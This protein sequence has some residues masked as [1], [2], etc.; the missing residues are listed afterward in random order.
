MKFFEV[1][2]KFMGKVIFKLGGQFGSGK[3]D[4]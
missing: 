2:V 1:I 4:D 3:E